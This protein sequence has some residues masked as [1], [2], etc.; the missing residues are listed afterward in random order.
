MSTSYATWFEGVTSFKPHDWQRALGEDAEFKDRLLRLPTGFGKT[1]GVV[2]AWLYQ[3]AAQGNP[4]W[5]L[6]LAYALPMRV[7]VEQSAAAIQA[8]LDSLLPEVKVDLHVLMGGVEGGRYAFAPETPTIVLGT[9]DMLLSRALNRGYGAGRA[10]WPID[11]GLLHTDTL[12]LMDEIQLMGVGLATSAQ[13]NAL[14]QDPPPLRPTGTWWM[15]ATLRPSWLKSPETEGGLGKLSADMVCIP[16]RAREGGLWNIRKPLERR[17][18]IREV[19]DLAQLVQEQHEAGTM[20]LVIVNRV[21]RAC[22]VH[23]ALVKAYSE[24]KGAK[25]KLREDAPELCL[26]HSRFRGHERAQWPQAFLDKE[27][28]LPTA[29][30]V[31]VATQVVEAGVDL[32]ARLLITDLAPW[33]SLVQR[34]GRCARRAWPVAEEGRLIV[35]GGPPTDTKGA[36][37]YTSVELRAADLALERLLQGQGSGDISALEAFGVKL[38]Q[39][40]DELLSLLYPYQPL[41]LLLRR[42]VLELFDTTPDLSGADLDVGR[43]IRE[44]VERDVLV[45]WRA[46][47]AT[48]PTLSKSVVGRVG[49]D[50]LCP[51]PFFA[52]R[53]WLKGQPAYAFDYL[54]GEWLRIRDLGRILPG[55]RILVDA[56]VGGYD[57]QRGWDPK[58][59]GPAPTLTTPAPADPAAERFEETAA[60]AEDDSLS[61]SG[62][63]TIATHGRETAEIVAQL[64][65]Q[66][67]LP[68]ELS[69]LLTLAARHHDSGKAAETFQA[70][71]KESSRSEVSAVRER[72]DLAKA[73]SQAWRRPA[74]PQRP[75]FRH[76]LVSVLALFELL[77]VAEPKHEALLGSLEGLF[78][79]LGEAPEELAPPGVVSE[80]AA[81]LAAL[82]ASEFDLV[83]YLV[84]SHHGK[85]RTSWSAT[86]K[87]L[88]R[89]LGA[90]HGVVTGDVFPETPL[91]GAD[92]RVHT[93]PELSLNLELASLGASARYGRSWSERVAG[94]LERHGPFKL[95]YLEALLRIADH[96][97]SALS[98]EDAS[99][100]L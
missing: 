57:P 53:K 38:E 8:W 68:A 6:R 66:L 14:R 86:P 51:V 100:D 16:D 90:I 12:W 71:I 25:R 21:D 3:R 30:R 47:E 52:A 60:A 22:A 40:G 33:P 17:A 49:R 43:Y 31:I 11:F 41:H 77:R 54:E 50:E 34:F 9:Q 35:V 80:L 56:K 76:E 70:A 79:L 65:E 1:A 81:E 44:G 36:L 97:S 82:S 48:P 88:K 39:D 72:R 78:E 5:P 87:D 55:M 92:G 62:W 75:G 2:L 84:V 74:Y 18:D 67:Q 98:K 59:K 91:T 26:V 99:L 69:S 83:A 7:L 4:Q 32:S 29:G 23:A 94:L 89:G 15:S 46:L 24:G 64:A 20:T 93:I 63:K 27:A 37:P 28:G 73:P 95:A 13:L 10:H 61:V 96:R 85:V 58:A 19:S 42:D 45:L